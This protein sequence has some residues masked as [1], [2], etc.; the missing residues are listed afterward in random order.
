MQQQQEQHSTVSL[1]YIYYSRHTARSVQLAENIYCSAVKASTTLHV[2]RT[3][4]VRACMCVFAK[5][6]NMRWTGSCSGRSSSSSSSSSSVGDAARATAAAT[7]NYTQ[8]HTL[9]SEGMQYSSVRTLVL[10]QSLHAVQFCNQYTIISRV[11]VAVVSSALGSL[12]GD[13][14]GGS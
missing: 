3:P 1:V 13:N 12:Q 4:V 8:W 2:L 5:V 9:Y 10:L 6:C 11:A 7:G 14:I